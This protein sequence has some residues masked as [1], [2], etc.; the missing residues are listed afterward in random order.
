MR[1]TACATVLALCAVARGDAVEAERDELIARIARGEAVAESVA[2]FARLYREHTQRLA[3]EHAQAEDAHAADEARRARRDAYRDSA[4]RELADHC[5]LSVDP[6]RPMISPTD[7]R[8]DWGRVIDKRVVTLRAKNPFAGEPDETVT[9]YTIA[10][11]AQTHLV[12]GE[13]RDGWSGRELRAD[14]GDLVLVC[15]SDPPT[16]KPPAWETLA[17]FRAYLLE[18][19]DEARQADRARA[20]PEDIV[21]RERIGAWTMKIAAPPRI[22]A[23]TRWNPVH[24]GDWE[25]YPA[26]TNA[27]W[28]KLPSP[29]V[30]LALEIDSAAGGGRWLVKVH[31]PMLRDASHEFL[32]EV[33]PGTPHTELLEPEAHVWAILGRPRFDPALRR[34]VLVAEDFESSYL[35]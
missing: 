9:Y 15:W 25:L 2:R 32:V 23:K 22:A 27:A 35:K 16:S 20:V 5:G 18:R 4:D 7:R 28:P 26:I 24:I 19:I 14:K 3:R 29:Y 6:A 8:S 12:R 13:R 17:E 34:L 1:R 10:G 21:V 31:D 33:P 11:R 30:L